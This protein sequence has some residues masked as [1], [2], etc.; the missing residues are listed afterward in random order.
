LAILSAVQCVV[1]L[2]FLITLGVCGVAYM[3]IDRGKYWFGLS[4][5]VLEFIG[6]GL[7][8]GFK[9]L[10]SKTST[11]IGVAKETDP[12]H[13]FGLGLLAGSLSFGGAYTTIPFLQAEAV[14]IGKWMAKTVFLDAIAIGQILPSPLVMFFHIHR[15]LWRLCIWRTWMGVFECYIDFNRNSYTMLFL[16]NNGPPSS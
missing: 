14:E 3:F 10:P 13:I 12:G 7:Y 9:G 11:G 4:V 16:Y 6:F 5:F 15:I 2:N 8:V 1:N